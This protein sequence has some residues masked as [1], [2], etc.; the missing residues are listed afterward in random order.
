[1]KAFDV[2]QDLNEDHFSTTLLR[3]GGNDQIM[4]I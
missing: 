2:L 1:M 3:G 4:L